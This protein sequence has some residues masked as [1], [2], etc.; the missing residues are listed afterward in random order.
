MRSRTYPPAET[1]FG[2]FTAAEAAAA[3]WTRSSLAHALR[4]E[5]LVRL[6]RGVYV[7]AELWDGSGPEQ[8]RMRYAMRSVAA[9]LAV[10]PAAASHASA[11]VLAGL[12]LWE[13]PGRPCVTVRPTYT[14]DARCAHLH[15]ARLDAVVP[16]RS[17]LR[18]S[19]ARLILD[20]AREHG[21]ENAVVAGDAALARRTVDGERLLRCA[22]FCA[23]WPGIRRAEKV[24]T[25]LDGRSESPL[26]S[27]S[28][29]RL[30]AA[31]LPRPE[32]QVDIFTREGVWLGRLDF[33]WEEFGVAGE[34]DGK[35]KYRDNPE[36]T[37]WREKRRQEA[38]EETNLVFARW[39]R[40]DLDDLARLSAKV[41]SAI[42][43]ASLMS[44]RN[45]IARPAY[46]SF[47]PLL[48]TNPAS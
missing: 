6:A 32:P 25:L 40:P 16:A 33:Y 4:T 30:D 34:V 14:G 13:L 43:R 39:G 22:E 2:V 24:L 9:V 35:A 5:R 28:R 41:N 12:P 48:H 44:T 8:E 45:W 18:T 17:G 36:E 26:E 1:R 37:W 38:M 11:A 10:R 23:G 19:V 46:T 42:G 27:I 47:A 15:R 7:P 20:L 21:I 3:G 29:L 31:G